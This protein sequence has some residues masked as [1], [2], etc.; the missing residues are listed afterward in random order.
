MQYGVQY[1][2]IYNLMGACCSF[3]NRWEK[4]Y[5][6]P[7]GHIRGLN[8]AEEASVK[9]LLEKMKEVKQEL[10]KWDFDTSRQGRPYRHG[11]NAP[12]LISELDHGKY[13]V[14]IMKRRGLIGDYYIF[15]LDNV[16]R[17]SVDNNIFCVDED[18]HHE[19]R[20]CTCDGQIL[21]YFGT[22]DEAMEAAMHDTAD[23]LCEIFD[24]PNVDVDFYQGKQVTSKNYKFQ[25]LTVN[26]KAL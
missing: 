7:N 17:N 9:T 20:L 14:K 25:I 15:R 16:Y 10:G 24:T 23:R 4:S 11:K 19:F 1:D 13:D 26:R 18:L 8:K 21:Q 6:E 2:L 12:C 22:L 5:I 3:I